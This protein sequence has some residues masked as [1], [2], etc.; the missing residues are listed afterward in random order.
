MNSQQAPNVPSQPQPLPVALAVVVAL[1][2]FGVTAA[3][4]TISALKSVTTD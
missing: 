1:A 2:V 3:G 4:A